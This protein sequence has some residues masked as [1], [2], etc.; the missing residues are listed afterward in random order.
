VSAEETLSHDARA[1][2]LDRYRFSVLS[3]DDADGYHRVM[4]PA[5]AAKLRC[6][7]RPESMAL[8]HSRPEILSAP[9]CTRRRVAPR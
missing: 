1:A 9:E 7:Q 6:P 2:E 3:T 5:A 8:A 4:C